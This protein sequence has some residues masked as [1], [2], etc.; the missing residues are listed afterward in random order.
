MLLSL[1]KACL[2]VFFIRHFS[3]VTVNYRANWIC[4]KSDWICNKSNC[5]LLTH[6]IPMHPFSTPW[7]HVFR[8]RERVHCKQMDSYITQAICTIISEYFKS[9]LMAAHWLYAYHNLDKL[10]RK[11]R[12]TPCVHNKYTSQKLWI[13]ASLLK[14]CTVECARL[15]ICH[16]LFR[17]VLIVRQA[18]S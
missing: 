17:C 13:Q 9:I 3:P 12:C 2:S 4:R 16:D 11:S 5:R 14:R 1:L 7:K 8:G 15:C 6:L 18:L 10:V